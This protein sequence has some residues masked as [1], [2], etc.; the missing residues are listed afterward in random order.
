MGLDSCYRHLRQSEKDIA[1][2]NKIELSEKEIKAL[3]KRAV[4][5]MC[6]YGVGGPSVPVKPRELELLCE[7]AL[8]SCKAQLLL[9]PPQPP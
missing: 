2:W 8:R 7:L 4:S 6:T 5:Y 1:A 3:L 9:F